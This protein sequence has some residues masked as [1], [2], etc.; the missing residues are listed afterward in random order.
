MEAVTFT[1]YTNDATQ[2]KAI[3]AF[4]KALKIKFELRK[5]EQAYDPAFVEKI[6]QGDENLK[7][8]KGRTITRTELDAL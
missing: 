7:N 4:M 8:S 5:E 6:Q 2:I 1:V 3:Q